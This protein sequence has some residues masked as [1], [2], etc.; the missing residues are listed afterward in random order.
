[1]SEKSATKLPPPNSSFEL[2]SQNTSLAFQRTRMA[3]DRTLMAV[4][5]TALSLI[6]FGFTIFKLAQTLVAEK[7]INERLGIPHYAISL[8]LIGIIMLAIGIIYHV[9]FMLGLRTTRREMIEETLIHGKN[10][11]PY[12]FTLLTATLLLA[13]G[14]AAIISMLFHVGPFE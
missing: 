6:S 13:L 5:R 9:Q 2:A 1:M 3:A 12:S 4:I 14:L 10:P 8:V 11:F 7:I